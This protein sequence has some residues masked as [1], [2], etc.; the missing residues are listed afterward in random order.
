MQEV[1]HA[2][3]CDCLGFKIN[4]F[5]FLLLISVNFKKNEKAYNPD[6]SEVLK[7][8]KEAENDQSDP[9]WCMDTKT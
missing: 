3:K 7:F 8:L 2:Q 9:G 6:G 4:T 1:H 5:L